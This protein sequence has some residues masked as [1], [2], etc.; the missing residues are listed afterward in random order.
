MMTKMNILNFF[1]QCVLPPSQCERFFGKQ[2]DA[3]HRHI[4]P[5]QQRIFDSKSMYLYMQGGVGGGKSE[6]FAR[7]CVWLA[8]TI[9]KN[10]GV[11]A[12]H[13]FAELF[14]SSWR[15]VNDC[16]NDLVEQ[17]LIPEPK[18]SR[19]EKGTYT[20]IQFHNGSELQAIHG[21]NWRQALGSDHGFFWVDDALECA[22]DFFIGTNVTAGLLSRLRLPHVRFDKRVYNEHTRPHGFLHGMVS[23]N[24]PPYG[25][26]LHDLFGDKEGT[27]KIGNDEV[28]WIRGETIDN[29]FTGQSYADSLVGAQVKMGANEGT[30]RRVIFGESVPAYKGIPCFPQFNHKKHVAAL[31]FNPTLPLIAAWDFGFRHPAIIFSHIYRCKYNFNHYFTLSEIANAFSLTVH[32]LYKDYYKPHIDA[33]YKDA[34]VILHAGDIAGWRSSSASKDTRG[35]MKILTY[36]YNLPFKKRYIDREQSLQYMR[37]LL[38]PKQPCK[39][40][41]ELILISEKCK[42][43]IGALEG[44]YHYPEKGV[45]EKPVEDRMFADVACAWRYG[46]EN[47]VRGGIPYQDEK[48]LKIQRE[49]E[50][51]KLAVQRA[52]ATPHGWMDLPDDRMASLITS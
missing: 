44:G 26:W 45:G 10:R 47:F 35:D 23:S 43:L 11:I 24:P 36:E 18:Y 40:G 6:G 30:I 39:C 46:A 21:K 12:R 5:A 22:R 9:P 50:A 41:L 27:H 48:I 37:S 2:T 52:L 7:K 14:D 38:R 3:I 20:L 16:I 4:L 34:R 1:P 33:L 8:L 13:N 28:E 19:K 42:A 32:E 25:H 15:K 51:H 31:K 29:P 49:Q 17:D